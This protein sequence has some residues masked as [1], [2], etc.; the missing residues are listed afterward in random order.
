MCTIRVK[1]NSLTTVRIKKG[2]SMNE[3]AKQIDSNAGVISRIENC[4]VNPRPKTAQ[5]ICRALGVQFE[6]IFEID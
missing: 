3:F 4:A 6:E 2:L 1:G 5:K